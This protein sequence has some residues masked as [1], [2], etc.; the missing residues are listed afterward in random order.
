MPIPDLNEDGLLPEG[1]HDCTLDE[2]GARFGRFQVTERRIQLFGKL[3]ALVDEERQAG[4]AVEL[5]VDGSF[6]T[7]KPEPGDIDLVIVLPADY[8]REG[9]FAPF[10]YNAISKVSIRRRYGFDVFVTREGT[11]DYFGQ[12]AFFQR[13][14]ESEL[15]KGVL[16]I[17]L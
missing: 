8:N 14:K 4:L 6:V 7:D 15:Q 13:V 1:I 16:R 10:R 9:E 3:R 5:I 12:I 2:I 17:K 11:S